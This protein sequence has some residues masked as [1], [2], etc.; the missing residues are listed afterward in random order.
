MLNSSEHCTDQ[1]TSALDA[2]FM[3]ADDHVT[4]HTFLYE[5]VETSLCLSLF[6][7]VCVF[8]IHWSG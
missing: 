3:Y 4:T 5:Q 7:C 8:I 2:C 1:S 6:V